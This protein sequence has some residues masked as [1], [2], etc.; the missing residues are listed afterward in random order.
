MAFTLEVEVEHVSVVFMKRVLARNSLRLDYF[1]GCS[2]AGGARVIKALPKGPSRHWCRVFRDTEP[3]STLRASST[4]PFKITLGAS[5]RTPKSGH[6][7]FADLL[8][9]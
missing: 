4:S 9:A 3:P 1:V 7:L 8:V 5:Q 6:S 2:G